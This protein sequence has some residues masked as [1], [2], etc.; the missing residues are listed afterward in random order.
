MIKYV[1]FDWDGTVS[2]GYSILPWTDN[3]VEKALF[4][5]GKRRDIREA[6]RQ[7]ESGRRGYE[8]LCEETA[9][10][11]SE[12]LAGR[13][14]T[15]VDRAGDEFVGEGRHPINP[16]FED[17]FMIANLNMI[18]IVVVS[19]APSSLLKAY[20]KKYH[21]SRVYSLD[22]EADADGRFLPSVRTNY[23]LSRS[24]RE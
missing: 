1:L 21:I 7:H 14:K 19:G 20:A 6:F 22:V 13:P 9:G 17:I 18:N 12:G 16:I 5:A 4:S 15:A 3:L 10:L 8:W 24:L 23:G 11:Y 2:P